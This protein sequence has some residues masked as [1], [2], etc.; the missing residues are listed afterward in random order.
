[1]YNFLEVV[2]KRLDIQFIRLKEELDSEIRVMRSSQAEKHKIGAG[3]H[4]LKTLEICDAKFQKL[5][6]ILTEEI[7]LVL[8]ESVVFSEGDARI[9]I[10]FTESIFSEMYRRADNHILMF[11]C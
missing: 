2:H 11:S 1:M 6:D 5:R 7:E 9:F 4:M 10:S 8:L 3:G